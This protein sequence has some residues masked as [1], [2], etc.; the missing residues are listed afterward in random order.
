MRAIIKRS[1]I[2]SILGWLC[3]GTILGEVVYLGIIILGTRIIEA[4]FS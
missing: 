2:R 1:H 4:M 3:I